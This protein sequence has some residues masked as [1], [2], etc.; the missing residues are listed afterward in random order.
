MN[1][2]YLIGI[3]ETI[4]LC[5]NHLY[6]EW[7]LEAIIIYKNIKLLI[8]QSNLYFEKKNIYKHILK[9][10]TILLLYQLNKPQSVEILLNRQTKAFFF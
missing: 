9:I 10:P 4:K 8:S 7:L 2:L 6:S 3:L 5:T 1:Y